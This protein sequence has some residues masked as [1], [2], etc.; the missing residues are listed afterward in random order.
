[1]TRLRRSRPSEPGY[2]RRRAGRGWIYLD[3]AGERLS[4][5]KVIERCRDLVIPPAWTEV[6]ICPWAHGHLQALGTDDAGRRQYLYHPQWR[7]RRDRDKHQRVLH[8]ARALPDARAQVERDL[9]LGDLS[10]N[11]VLAV[12]FRLLD[13]GLFRV[14]GETYAQDNGSYGLAT[15][16]REHVRVTAD[17]VVFDYIAKSGKQRSLVLSDERCAEA[18]ATLKRRTDCNAEL[19][20]WRETVSPVA[21]RDLTSDDVN[22][23]VER[24]VG[25][26]MTA[27]DFR[28]WHGTVLAA[29][30]LALSPPAA[31]LSPSKRSRAV[32]SA[33][34]DVSGLLGNTPSVARASYV[35]PRVVDL[36]EDGH[37]IGAILGETAADAGG[38]DEETPPTLRDIY[39]ADRAACERATLALLVTPPERVDRA[40]RRLA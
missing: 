36:W 4:D 23:Y 6:W 1:M 10:R 29:T 18:I 31:D 15:L 9:A 7:V 26:N 40:I 22:E 16:R 5:P 28:T 25:A 38:G 13:I 8:V 17:G 19:L 33:M 30:A 24:V 37:S 11:H 39:D 20:A 12:A 14:G 34:R 3:E 21:W 32:A 35:D 27:K 2:G